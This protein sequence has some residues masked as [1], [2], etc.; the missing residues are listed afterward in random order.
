[1]TAELINY[2]DKQTIETIKRS[3]AVGATNEEFQLFIHYCR[4][5]GLNPFRREIWFIK[6]G[7]RPQIMIGING[8]LQVANRHQAY[9]GME[10]DIEL[11]ADGNPRK[12]TAKV[13]RKDRKYPSVG[14]ALMKE[15]RKDTPIWKALPSVMLAKVAKSIAIREAFAIELT[16][17]YTEEE[18][19]EGY[20]A[21]LDVT[22]R[23]EE[24]EK[25]PAPVAAPPARRW[26][27]DIAGKLEGRSDSERDTFKLWL[28]QKGGE[29]DQ[30]T[31]LWTF[32]DRMP[33]LDL[34]LVKQAA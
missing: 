13:Y 25:A 29:F 21:P 10:V 1:M 23:T 2:E 26:T 27:Y 31:G 22:P 3:I 18:M 14:I 32:G 8:Y 28:S 7:N 12:A 15:W 33:A 11:S 6:T 24:P 30:E 17:T 5:T 16:G 19:P 4:T 20:A 34:Y 9:D